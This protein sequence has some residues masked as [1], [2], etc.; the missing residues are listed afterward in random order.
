MY[1]ASSD[2]SEIFLTILYGIAVKYA[3]KSDYEMVH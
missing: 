2:I 3:K 1:I